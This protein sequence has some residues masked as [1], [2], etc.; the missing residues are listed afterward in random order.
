VVEESEAREFL[1]ARFGAIDDVEPFQRGEWSKAFGYQRR[2]EEYVVRFSTFRDDFEKDRIAGG[3]S[4][5]TLP[6]PQVIEIGE[7]LGG[8]YAST[9]RVR[10][11][12]LESLDEARMR[13]SLPSLFA[14]LDAAREI[15][16]SS[17]SGYGLWNAELRGQ[18]AS[19][20]E[21]L[22]N[23]GQTVPPERVAGWRER[24]E[25]SPTGAEPFDAAYRRL[26][27][28]VDGCPEERH[29]V[30]SDLLYYNVLVAGDRLAAVLDWGSSIYG[31]F[32]WDIAWFTF[33]SP[34]YPAW[35]RIDFAAEA[36]SH[37]RAI[38]V[39]VPRFAER[40]RCYEIRIGLSGMSYQA[41]KGH[42]GELAAT[43]KRTLQIADAG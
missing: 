31:D 14:A 26:R 40:L 28:L 18:N 20:R 29:L 1:S 27:A 37:Y 25:A 15:D 10:G 5:R 36:A 35:S 43:A 8:F 3:Y 24:L 23:I 22:L 33:W 13:Q 41:W 11:E 39:P 19:W 38:G 12:F 17:A 21:M 32:L 34:W 30:Y 2:G 16:L 9:P 4:S 42:W 7:A 6:V